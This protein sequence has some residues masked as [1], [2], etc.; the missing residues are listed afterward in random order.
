MTDDEYHRVTPEEIKAEFAFQ[1]WAA[2][3]RAAIDEPSL[4]M[5]PYYDALCQETHDEFQRAFARCS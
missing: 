2:L 3:R 5:N 4:M 1:V